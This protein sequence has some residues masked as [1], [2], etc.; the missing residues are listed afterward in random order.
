MTAPNSTP[1]NKVNFQLVSAGDGTVI[2]VLQDDSGN[3]RHIT[4][5]WIEAINMSMGLGRVAYDTAQHIEVPADV[6][7]RVVGAAAAEMRPHH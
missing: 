2:L 6:W 7:S 4:M 1:K 5:T 3:Q